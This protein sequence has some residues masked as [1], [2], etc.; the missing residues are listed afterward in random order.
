MADQEY[1]LDIELIKRRAVSGVV[2][3]TLRTIFIQ[4]FTFLATFIL[5]I[6]LD[7]SIFGIF[8]VVSALINFFIYFS[9]IGLAAALV[10]KK[11]KPTR[12][13]LVTTFTIQQFIILS[14]VIIGL[15]FSS[16]IA[17]F[18]KLD[19]SGL[20][21][22]RALVFS[23]LLSSLK[24]IPS[25]L[26]ERKL[27]FT[28]LVIPQI[29]E[30]VIFYT[31]AVILAFFK[32]G[33]TSFAWATLSRG[34]V[35][36]V[37][38]YILSP[39]RPALGL[40]RQSAKSLTSFGIPFQANSILALLKDD[41]L[42]AF[43]GKI[44]P[45]SQVGYVGW[46]QKWAFVPLR[47]FMDNV[48]K[49]IF[50][51]Y[52]RLQEYQMELGKAI[53]KSLFFVTYFVY[54]SVFGMAAIAPK[55]IEVIP[56][57]QKW[58]PAL[59]LLYLFAVNAVFSAISTTLTNALF[60]TGRPKIVLNLMIF[61]TAATWLL[62]YPLVLKFGYI[63]VGLASALVA[64]TSISTIYFVK[65]Q[66]PVSVGKNIFGPLSLSVLMF[67]AVRSLQSIIATNILGLILLIVLGAII[68]F[69]LSLAIFKK[70]LIEDAKIILG[71]LISKSL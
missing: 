21:L 15:L 27:N 4:L 52:S 1:Q 68:Y 3:L 26:L 70:H 28:R 18:Y 2:T 65:Q 59:P 40:D 6:L 20:L 24:T 55:L 71:S 50:P 17:A 33:I 10:Q 29:A 57:Y 54:P 49:V 14:L 13:D 12:K 43:L 47:F 63:G 7:P 36:L 42:T 5:T 9:D 48:N 60:A 34:I 51:A 39:W 22:L 56:K 23:L 67:F 19:A 58:E 53:E 46:A 16:K 30:N 64:V 25:I 62:T 37:L 44:L 11:E 35:G 66:M 8:F 38:I 31:V 32:F 69:V 61:W 45:F 41:L